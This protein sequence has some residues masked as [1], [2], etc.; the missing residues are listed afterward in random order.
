M[1]QKQMQ[2]Y[3]GNIY[4]ADLNPVIGSEQGDIRP[5]L[6][7]QNDI[8][9]K[10]SPTIVIAPITCNL[11]KKF[12]PTHVPV[13]HIFGLEKN[14]LALVEQIRTIDRS[15]IFEYIGC[16]T[17]QQQLEIDCALAICVGIDNL[18]SIKKDTIALS[19]CPRCE[20]NFSQSDCVL[21]KRGWQETKKFCD[22]CESRQGLTFEVFS[23]DT[24]STLPLRK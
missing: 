17:K 6:V 19:L 8:G 11:N 5:V 16:I 1:K 18:H 23:K 21:V 4:Y 3:R 12:L 20:S 13:S 9:N 10:Y 24:L 7:V 22:F 14:S 2:I 15:R